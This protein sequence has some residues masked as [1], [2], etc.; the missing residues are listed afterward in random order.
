VEGRE[1]YH[2]IELAPGVV[3]PGFFDHRSVAPK[4]LPSSLRGRRCLDVATFD[5]FWALQMRTRHADEVVAV[6]VPDPRDWDWPVGASEA[7]MAAIGGRKAEGD[8]FRIATEALG[9][10]IDRI[11]CSVYDLDASRIGEF[12]FVYVGSLLLHLRDPVRA[13]ERVRAVCRGELLL[14]ENV[15]PIM[16]FLHPRRP[17]ATFDGLGRPWWWRLNL[18]ALERVV[19][20]AGFDPQGRPEWV[21]FPKGQGRNVP[22]LRLSTLRERALRTELREGMFGDPHAVLRARPRPGL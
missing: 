6:D 16:T 4:I 10:D 7:V 9:Y 19:S 3:T 22:P 21:R 2:T 11:E 18:A 8:G 14:V 17:V 13:L 15:D 20:S 1:W 5:G 12:D